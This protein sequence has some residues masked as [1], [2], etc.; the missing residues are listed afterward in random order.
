VE[1]VKDVFIVLLLLLLLL[2][3]RCAERLRRLETSPAILLA[4]VGEG[5]VEYW[6]RGR[7]L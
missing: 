7:R 5:E 4:R 3:R 2:S 6:G 1:K